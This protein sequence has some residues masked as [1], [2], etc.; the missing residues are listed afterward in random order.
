MV[1]IVNAT[2]LRIVNVGQQWIKKRQQQIRNNICTGWA[3]SSAQPTALH[4][5]SMAFDPGDTVFV[6][7]IMH[8]KAITSFR[9]CDLVPQKEAT[10][11]LVILRRY[12]NAIYWYDIFFVSALF[13]QF[14]NETYGR[15]I[16]QFLF[17]PFDL[18]Q[19]S[20]EKH[21]RQVFVGTFGLNGLEMV[22][23]VWCTEQF[24]HE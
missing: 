11:V 5:H 13:L 4:P 24:E 7:Y 1:L 6:M 12:F 20:V 15:L 23:G 14:L 9:S 10:R 18:A 19:F 3:D 21:S 17:N 8:E 22:A 2:H 16:N